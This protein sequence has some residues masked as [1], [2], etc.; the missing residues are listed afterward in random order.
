MLLLLPLLLVF[1]FPMLLLIIVM[2][3][4][5]AA[6]IIEVSGAD[7]HHADVLF[8]QPHSTNDCE[9]QTKTNTASATGA[10]VR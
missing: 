7:R 10:V 1:Q 8:F 6:V 5:V 3:V 2:A 4:V 9:S